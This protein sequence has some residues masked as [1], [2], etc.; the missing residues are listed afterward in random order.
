M[1]N[2]RVSGEHVK[3]LREGDPDTRVSGEHVKVL[4]EGVPFTRVSAEHVKVLVSLTAQVPVNPV[5]TDATPC[6]LTFDWVAPFIGAAS[7]DVRVDGGATVVLGNVLTYTTPETLAPSTLHAFEVRSHTADGA[8]STWSTPVSGTTD[9]TPTPGPVVVTETTDLIQV[10]WPDVGCSATYEA[11]IDGGAGVPATSP[12]DFTGFFD[13]T[14][15]IEVRALING[16]Y[17]EWGAVQADVDI[18]YPAPVIFPPPDP[19]CVPVS[20]LGQGN[21]TVVVATQGGEQILGELPASNLDWGRTLDDIADTNVTIPV[22]SMTDQC[23]GLLA[24]THTWGHELIVYR[25]GERV[26]E[27]PLVRI[28]DS[29]NGGVKIRAL[30]VLGYTLRRGHRGRVNAAPVF[31]V[32]EA[33]FDVTGAFTLDGWDLADPNVLPY[34]TVLGAGTGPQTQ[35][36]IAFLSAYYFETLDQIGD[37][38]VNFTTVGR[39]IILWPDTMTLGRVPTLLPSQHLSTDVTIVEDGLA[40]SARAIVTSD[41]GLWGTSSAPSFPTSDPFYGPV[42]QIINIPNLATSAACDSAADS[43]RAQTFPAPVRL[44]IPDGSTLTSDAPYS[45]AD[46]VPG[47][48]MPVSHVGRCRTVQGDFILTSLRVTQTPEGETVQISVAPVTSAVES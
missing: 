9:P 42:E 25:D 19:L 20:N 15:L 46:L 39:R 40:L 38:G 17:G 14:Y 13:G 21:N 28:E 48:L 4:R 8:V 45:V 27:G 7:Y 29:E 3:V 6:A 10:S 43:I 11:R 23:C 18:V 12:H 41:N 1:A 31:A 35:R 24:D 16:V 32:D 36:D 5:L 47:V 30:D 33:E 2:T 37:A 44:V 26:S 34:L 22:S